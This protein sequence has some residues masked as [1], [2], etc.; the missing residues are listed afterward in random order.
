MSFRFLS[1]KTLDFVPGLEDLAILD[2]VIAQV[3]W[4]YLTHQQE[5]KRI[6]KVRVSRVQEWFLVKTRIMRHLVSL[7]IDETT[8]SEVLLYLEWLVVLPNSWAKEY[9]RVQADEQQK[10]E[11]V[12]AFVTSWERVGRMVGKE[13]GK[14]EGKIEALHETILTI[15][16]KKYGLSNEER[17]TILNLN[18]YKK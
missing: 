2:K 3:L 8:I 12:M 9:Y 17:Q 7:K 4:V 15:L 11:G 13:E 14:K 16:E 1:A 6:R 10:K 5:K 18:P